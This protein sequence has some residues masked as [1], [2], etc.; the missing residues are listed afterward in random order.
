M[1]LL[2]IQLLGAYRRR[3]VIETLILIF[4]FTK[5]TRAALCPVG[6]SLRK[7]HLIG[8][9]TC[10]S[11][12]TCS[13]DMFVPSIHSSAFPGTCSSY[14]YIATKIFLLI[15][16]SPK[17]MDNESRALVSRALVQSLPMFRVGHC[18]QNSHLLIS[19]KLTPLPRIYTGWCRSAPPSNGCLRIF[20]RLQENSTTL[21]SSHS[22]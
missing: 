19:L 21:L 17:P 10:S 8:S 9:M 15:M 12:I 22:A 14:L 5:H 13:F 16:P 20:N 18:P 1:E 2:G 3:V 4:E 7:N 6:Q 11:A